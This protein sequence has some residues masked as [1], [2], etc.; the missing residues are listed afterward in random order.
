MKECDGP[1][2]VTLDRLRARDREAH[3]AHPVGGVLGPITRRWWS[4]AALVSRRA[5]GEERGERDE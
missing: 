2:E 3:L 1:V 4:L 5:G